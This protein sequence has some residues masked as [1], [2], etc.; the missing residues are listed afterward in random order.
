MGVGTETIRARWGRRSRSWM[1]GSKSIRAATA[2][3]WATAAS[4][5]TAVMVLARGETRRSSRPANGR[6][7]AGDR[8]RVQ[9]AEAHGVRHALHRQHQ[10]GGAQGYLA[11][12][13]H[14]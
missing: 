3:S 5:T 14:G 4:S 13:G 10:G 6:A 12:A 2:S 7:S 1:P 11:L 9:A 8:S